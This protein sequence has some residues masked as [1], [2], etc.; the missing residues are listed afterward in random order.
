MAPAVFVLLLLAGCASREV[1]YQEGKGQVAYDQ[2]AQE[3]RLI[4]SEFARQA[5]MTGKSEDPATYARTMTTCLLS[6]GWHMTPPQSATAGAAGD[7]AGGSVPLADIAAGEV[8]AFGARIK[9]PDHFVLFNTT[10]SGAGPTVLQTYL[11]GGPQET[12]INVMVQK[13]VVK[14]N[15]FE[16]T[17]YQVLPPF[18][19]YEQGKDGA[20]IF[21][22]KINDEWVMGLGNFFVINGQERVTVIVTKALMAPQTEAQPGFRLSAEQFARVEEFKQEWLSWLTA[23][24]TVPPRPWWSRLSWPKL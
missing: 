8:R 10:D 12:Y 15:R 4:A 13:T 3:C 6:K 11:F 9:L 1:W 18:F 16:D 20:A 21:C 7:V 19:L 23:E 24:V 22:G 2:D 17:P 14:G 5:T